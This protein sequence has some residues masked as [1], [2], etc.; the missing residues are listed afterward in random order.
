MFLTGTYKEVINVPLSQIFLNSDYRNL[1]FKESTKDFIIAAP[2]QLYSELR[3]G[4]KANSQ[5]I[6]SKLF[7]STKSRDPIQHM[8]ALVHQGNYFLY[9]N[10]G[11]Y[12]TLPQIQHVSACKEKQA[13][14]CYDIVELKTL[15]I[16]ECQDTLNN[17]YFSIMQN[18]NV[19][20]LEVE[21]PNSEFRKLD[22]VD[23]YL[24]R[25]T[26]NKI[27]LYIE[28]QETLKFLKSL[29][30][31]Q[32]IDLL[33]KDNFKLSIRDFQAHTNGQISIMNAF[34]EIVV[35]EYKN[36]NWQLIKTIDTEMDDIQG[37]DY[38]IYTD[39]Y[40]IMNKS[41]IRYKQIDEE[42]QKKEYL[43]FN[44]SNRIYLTNGSVLLH[45]KQDITLFTLGL[46]KL[47]TLNL[48]NQSYQIIT[49]PYS[50]G[51]IA[52]SDNMTY[53]YSNNKEYFL[54]VTFNQILE[55]KYL[56]VVLN[57]EDIPWDCEIT[58]F[59]KTENINNDQIITQQYSQGL[60]ASGV[61][62]DKAK[63]KLRP[64]FQ[65][66]NLQYNFQPNSI[67]SITVNQ[68]KYAFLKNV[69]ESR[70]I[71]YREILQRRYQPKL[72]LVEQDSN[73]QLIG[74]SCTNFAPIHLNCH[75]LFTK[76]EFIKLSATQNQLWWYN[77]DSLFF[78]VFGDS[79]III[80]TYIYKDKKLAVLTAIV[81]ESDIKQIATDGYH[82]FASTAQ[83]VK[84]Y[85]ITVAGKEKLLQTIEV[86]VDKLY[87]S[88]AQKNYMFLEVA[89]TLYIYNIAYN[90]ETLIQFIEIENDYEDTNLAI[91]D[92]YFV[93]FGKIKDKEE[94][95]VKMY[96]YKNQ[97]NIYLQKQIGING[98]SKINLNNMKYSFINNLFYLIGWNTKRQK[99]VVLIY[100][101]KSS[102]LDSLFSVIDV[103][104]MAQISATGEYIFITDKGN[105]QQ[106]LQILYIKGQL[107]VSAKI[108]ENYQQVE[109]SK[110][111]NLSLIINNDSSNKLITTIPVNI[112][113]RG[114][115]LFQINDSF[116]LT[117][118]SSSDE[119]HCV[120]LGQS[121]YSGQALDLELAEPSK[122]VQFNPVL[123][124]Q[125]ETLEFSVY[126]REFDDDTLVQMM[127]NKLKFLRKADLSVTE[128]FQLDQM[129]TFH[130]MFL[131]DGHNI[132]IQV[133]TDDTIELRIVQCQKYKCALLENRLEFKSMIK[134]VYLH[135]N[136]F[137][138]YIE[139]L[140]EVYDTKGAA[141]MLESFEQIQ[142]F[143]QNPDLIQMEFRHLQ[144]D[145]YQFI[146][147]DYQ[148]NPELQTRQIS[149]TSTISNYNTTNIQIKPIIAEYNINVQQQQ[150]SDGFVLWK[151][152]IIIIFKNSASYSFKFQNDCQNKELCEISKFQ[153]NGVYQ[154][155]G[156]WYLLGIFQI[157]F[158]SQNFLHLI[159]FQADQSLLLIY[160]LSTP[161]SNSKPNN[162]IVGITSPQKIGAPIYQITSFVYSSDEKLHLLTSIED[163]DQLQHYTIQRSPQLCIDEDFFQDNVKFKLSNL[164]YQMYLDEKVKIQEYML[165]I[166]KEDSFP[167]WAIVLIVL[168]TVSVLGFGLFMYRQGK[169]NRIKDQRVLLN[170]V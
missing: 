108:N 4:E 103:T 29:D 159:Y 149:R 136:Y 111:I 50:N 23:S 121:W 31:L 53:A 74:Y 161:S 129:Y 83:D 168:G 119:K 100:S 12:Q 7:K 22:Q 34:G 138:V 127:G 5:T 14:I 85:S 102:S 80:Y 143:Q 10:V 120:D 38:D 133:I 106:N 37:Y 32:L 28:E 110:Q 147:V 112:V 124:K 60:I 55:Q 169:R 137:F 151:D 73:L 75:I 84:I 170:Q 155:Y 89:R 47:Q 94:Y 61:Y 134:N 154:Q 156:D 91:F 107:F 30:E 105:N 142:K 163:K 109:Y 11:I 25:G 44:E 152:E 62:Q 130:K 78:A 166:P 164:D 27:D 54:Q 128:E 99:H 126:I 46:A 59:Y 140:V 64:V 3:F 33:Q 81:L 65:G 123:T 57:Q 17:S 77:E 43:N 93:R 26:V 45:Q 18:E 68:F 92:D 9:Q 165:P 69:T 141:V 162:A 125:K 51:F 131:I 82:L 71:I 76:P 160:D 86:Q 66:S 20:Q 157:F 24:I 70:Y 96:N 90:K 98:Y 2:I 115:K 167:A 104:F 41:E 132:Y 97:K 118:K 36:D 1:T 135:M 8:T 150:F 35:V 79:T 101:T 113:N 16:V 40:V 148:G 146:S 117:Y 58:I 48:G 145:I 52:V 56:K 15:V 21:K 153:L 6:S 87:A 144:K 63:V 19:K 116:N 42:C 67:I 95:D 158:V 72:Y 39:S 139:S 114:V 13:S 88:E 122:N 49:N